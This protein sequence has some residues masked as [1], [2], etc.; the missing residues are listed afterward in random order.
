MFIDDLKDNVEAARKIGIRVIHHVP[1][2]NLRRELT[3][4]GVL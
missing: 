3:A 4:L 1:G 2:T